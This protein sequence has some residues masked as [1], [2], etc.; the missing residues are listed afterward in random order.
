MPSRQPLPED[1]EAH[2]DHHWR[3]DPS[4]A[5]TSPGA[6]ERFIEDVGF[7][8]CLTDA[9]KPGP[10]LFIAVCGRRDA[11]KPRNVQTD[12]ETSDTW[13]LKDE[14]MR[15]GKVYYAKMARGKAMFLAPRMIPFFHAVW[16]VRRSDESRRLSRSARA[17]L[18]VG[19]AQPQ[20]EHD[21]VVFGGRRLVDWLT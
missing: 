1:I 19:D 8:H 11:V 6:A 20:V 3:R 14:L 5:V 10:S 2:R 7:L 12:P 21:P 9:R 15:R 16:G 18:R 13:R 17:I 4:R